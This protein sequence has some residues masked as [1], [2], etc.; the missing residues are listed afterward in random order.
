MELKRS[1]SGMYWDV[2]YNGFPIFRGNKA[3]C[4][5]TIEQLKYLEP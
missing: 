2:M 3:E 5:T 4:L 1:G